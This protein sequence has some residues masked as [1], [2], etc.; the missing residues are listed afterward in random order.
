MIIYES[1]LEGYK[2]AI[3]DLWPAAK[4]EIWSTILAQCSPKLQE[5]LERT[6]EFQQAA[7][8]QNA[9]K[10]L[11]VV[12]V[13]SSGGKTTG[14]RPQAKADRLLDLV[15]FRQRNLSLDQYLNEF[16]ACYAAFKTLGGDLQNQEDT[17]Q[18][19][20][21]ASVS[22]KDALLVCLFL[23]NATYNKYG[24]CL[25]SL[26]NDASTKAIRYPS[27]L[28]EAYTMLDEYVESKTNNTNNNNNNSESV[29]AYVELELGQRD[30]NVCLTSTTCKWFI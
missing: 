2:R 16:K 6:N 25:R 21:G 13:L 3:G 1:K 30:G 4:L 9:I 17:W 28:E 10:L 5:R 11:R 20:D 29:N 26:R 22:T 18:S 27:T 8:N 19:A 24:E 7:I 15:H 14:F 23:N 12:N